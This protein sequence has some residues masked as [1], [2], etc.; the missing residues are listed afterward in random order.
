MSSGT[1]SAP[2]R[3][4]RVVSRLFQKND[5]PKDEP[6][7][8]PALFIGLYARAKHTIVNIPYD[9]CFLLVI[10]GV[11]WRY[12]PRGLDTYG[13]GGFQDQENRLE[14]SRLP[15]FRTFRLQCVEALD[16]QDAA[17]ITEPRVRGVLESVKLKPTKFDG[18][19]HDEWIV[20]AIKVGRSMASVVSLIDTYSCIQ[21]ELQV[22]GIVSESVQ[23][24]EIY[25]NAMQF[26][27]TNEPFR[28]H[29]ALPTC[30]MSGTPLTSVAPEPA[31]Y[32]AN[33]QRF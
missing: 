15:A 33:G 12:Y 18:S 23:A 24:T 31:T 27:A 6:T 30:S 25:A 28:G 26:A 2:G 1:L 20:D 10:D 5:A 32:R 7:P 14:I 8:L 16:V 4:R 17:I 11:T 22:Q 13:E 21:Q 29:V 3:I 9:P 19:I